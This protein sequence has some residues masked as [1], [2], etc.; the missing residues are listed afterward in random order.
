MKQ[1][2]IQMRSFRL[3]GDNRTLFCTEA[4]CDY[5]LNVLGVYYIPIKGNVLPGFWMDK[6]S[7]HYLPGSR[8]KEIDL[9]NSASLGGAYEP[10]A[11]LPGAYRMN[12]LTPDSMDES[13]AEALKQLKKSVGN[14]AEFVAER[15]QYSLA[16]LAECLSLEQI[17][18]VALAIYNCEA[19]EQGII[20][21]DQTG[22]GKGRVASAFI[23]YAVKSGK[24]PIFFTE[25]PGLFSDIYRDLTAIHS[26]DLRP[27]IVNASGGNIL[28]ED[29][30]EVR[31][32]AYS[33]TKLE[34][35]MREGKVPDDCDFV[36]VTYSQ[37]RTDDSNQKYSKCNFIS[38]IAKDNILVLDE[39]H[40][41]GGE[42]TY[43]AK[44]KKF[45]GNTGLIFQTKILPFCKGIM[46]LSATYAKYP[47]NM[48]IY[49]M[50]TCISDIS[51]GWRKEVLRTADATVIVDSL[52]KVPRFFK[53]LP[54]QE[55]IS[56]ALSRHGQFVRR[57]RKT[58]GM[59]VD[60]ITLDA[61]GAS[62]YGVKD[63]KTEHYE[64]YTCITSI[65]NSMREFQMDY[66]IPYL[67]KIAEEEARSGNRTQKGASVASASIFSSLFHL[68]NNVLLSLK[69][70][71]IAERAVEYIS[72][73]R[74][75]VIAL[76][77]TN[78]SILDSVTEDAEDANVINADY[79][80]AFVK[81]FNSLMKYYITEGRTKIPVKIGLASLGK[82]AIEAYNDIV[83]R[84][85][86]TTTG[87]C[88]SPIDVIIHK[89]KEAGYDV[90]ECTG[91]SRCLDLTDGIKY[92]KVV[93]APKYSAQQGKHVSMCYN[94]FNANKIDALIINQSG[95]T[96]KSAHAT[97][98]GTRLKKSEV[99]QR[100][101]L[102]A[103]AELDVNTEVQKRGRINRTGQLR[104]I[105]PLYEYIYSAIP[106]EKRFMMMLK[107][108]L[109]SLDANTTANQKQSGST[110]LETPDFFNKYGDEV[111]KRKLSKDLYTNTR[112]NDPLGVDENPITGKTD[113]M[114]VD[115]IARTTFGRM[116]VLEPEEQEKWYNEVLSE[117]TEVIEDLKRKDEYDLEIKEIDYQARKIS[118]SVLHPASN[119]E[120]GSELTAASFITRYSVKMPADKERTTANLTDRIN[121][122]A[123]SGQF[124]ANEIIK[125]LDKSLVNAE[126]AAKELAK[127]YKD[128]GANTR[129]EQVEKAQVIRAEKCEQ[130]KKVVSRL[131]A[132]AVFLFDENYYV[133][134]SI[135]VIDEQADLLS[136]P[137]AIVANFVNTDYS[138]DK[139][140]AYNLAETGLAELMALT[141]TPATMKDYDKFTRNDKRRYEIN[142]LTGNIVFNLADGTV[143]TRYT[144]EDGSKEQGI[145]I[146]EEV[147]DGVRS[148]PDWAKWTML[149]LS[150]KMTKLVISTLT[151]GATVPFTHEDI[152]GRFEVQA[153]RAGDE[154]GYYLIA[155][156]A[157]RE[158]LAAK[159]IQPFYMNQIDGMRWQG[160]Y[161]VGAL[162]D[163]KGF[164]E[165]LTQTGKM[166]VRVARTA[167]DKY[168]DVIDNSKYKATD[169]AKLSYDK[170]KIPTNYVPKKK[171]KISPILIAEL[172]RLSKKEYDFEIINYSEKAW[173]VIGDTKKYRE[174]LKDLG[175]KWNA[176][177]S[178]G[179][180]W[181]ISKK[182]T[183]EDIYKKLTA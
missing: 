109:K 43:H 20:I 11:E 126:R 108:K 100:V 182:Y 159:G 139:E 162:R 8:L 114:T 141:A 46:Y 147:K 28:D 125:S 177:L 168:A 69:A 88:F 131:R 99:K 158:F 42:V 84:F 79:S 7:W 45:T 22:I 181:V 17:D 97:E 31:G 161:Y 134:T 55:I 137:S 30:N 15:L 145:I 50:N 117:Y 61:E 136:R 86:R 128:V 149:D 40:N 36:C 144:L 41:A 96:G 122:N 89:I 133:L 82:E 183:E 112:L 105:P 70:E 35:A 48:P 151:D 16:E 57:E 123:D 32:M 150:P 103:Q 170:K 19:R 26:D 9:Q 160:G 166:S 21:G 178:C 121:R 77:D 27:L 106:C 76:A 6:K 3:K 29:G 104:H 140:I 75:V 138:K 152:D 179:A 63:L 157:Y 153:R 12:I 81:T 54:A 143:I 111:V 67:R 102:I 24:K 59:R 148:L 38:E 68:V 1:I 72:S 60:Y 2:D 95:S 180:G 101:M 169:W 34:A 130:I 163:I 176:R 80:M 53:T 115:E 155:A 74:K 142:I 171:V 164:L 175:G 165:Y 110:V 73:G 47:K 25:K 93:K 174:A 129:A 39:S 90:A 10:A 23:R 91:R 172:Q 13:T 56:S 37:L 124:Q 66:I 132:G 120:G 44:T 14:V 52:S 119:K 98:A 58:D 33:K 85:K 83:A 107:M 51:K 64:V 135:K 92:A 5:N 78:E 156:G 146:K 127:K 65:V 167:L 87:L 94:N 173:A 4:K 18:A 154:M 62:E 49:A 71:A 116:Q 118:E 113:K